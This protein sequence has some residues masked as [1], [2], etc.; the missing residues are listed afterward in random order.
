M[1]MLFLWCDTPQPSFLFTASLSERP[2]AVPSP[3]SKMGWRG[4][5]PLIML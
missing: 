3:L 4:S 5:G 2:L 1:A